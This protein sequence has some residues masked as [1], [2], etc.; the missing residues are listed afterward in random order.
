[1]APPAGYRAG[2]SAATIPQVS[3]TA[4]RRH[5]TGGGGVPSPGIQH[6]SG[7]QPRC[8]AAMVPPPRGTRGRPQEVK[9]WRGPHGAGDRRDTATGVWGQVPAAPGSRLEGVQVRMAAWEG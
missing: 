8:R 1:M 6:L 2:W 4:G 9:C 7:I 5:S 3:S